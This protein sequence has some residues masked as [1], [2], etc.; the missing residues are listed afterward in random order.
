MRVKL[1]P[2][3]HFVP[4]ARGLYCA[5]GDHT[6]VLAS[7]PRLQ[8]LLDDRLGELTDGADAAD[9]LGSVVEPTER[10][11]LRQVLA[12]L[13]DQGVLF[14]L[15]RAGGPV[16]DLATA[17]RYGD[18]LAHYEEH[19]AEP[20]A[21]FAVLRAAEVAVLGEG[22][23]A[24][25]ATRG[26]LNLG[27]GTVTDR[28]GPRTAAAVLAVA[29]PVELSELAALLPA[30]TPYIPV[31]AGD[32]HQI[33]G[34]VLRGVPQA[35]A[36]RAAAERAAAWSRSHPAGR[37]PT[38]HA[39]TLAGSLAARGIL[40]HLGATALD[41]PDLHLIHGRTLRTT[42]HPF[43]VRPAGP[44]WSPVTHQAPAEADDTL[45]PADSTADEPL[46]TRWSGLGQWR[47]DLDLPQLPFRL[48]ALEA[49]VLPG[50]PVLLGW[51]T[52]PEDA[53]RD[54]LLRLLR[55][56]AED[57]RPDPA[58]PGTAAAGTT[59]RRW[60]LD[61]LLRVLSAE[62][63]D[64]GP[65]LPGSELATPL[66][67]SLVRALTHYFDRPAGLS[68]RTLPGTDW[69]LVTVTHADTGER[70]ARQWGPSAQ[71]AAQAA[72][73][74]ALAGLQ[75]DRAAFAAATVGTR[76]L[77]WAGP[78][79]LTALDAALRS[80]EVLRGRAV[81]ARRLTTDPVLGPVPLPCGLIWLADPP[82]AHTR[83]PE[84]S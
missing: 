61:G 41:T 25:S 39:A 47:D 75:Q 48:A 72:L 49:I 44:R 69:T 71:A 79:E 3:A 54:A 74:R 20:Y 56:T 9:L 65:P 16:P 63:T 68:R 37:A 1:R 15:D 52:E 67:R 4:M 29:A 19:C 22:P 5:R 11:A 43:T 2:G 70:L 80:P 66:A 55:A 6:F 31:P 77:E 62:E 42:L 45:P 8:R 51:G 57:V 83:A 21:A 53:R 81:H 84:E 34:P 10:V 64:D 27:V 32:G 46:T 17:E 30:D 59:S 82:T 36:F 28:P 38:L 24:R 33:V 73:A 40:D 7:P 35:R 13:L 12:A 78:T 23:A 60:L 26:L 18:A 58:H 14:D 50:Q 76:A